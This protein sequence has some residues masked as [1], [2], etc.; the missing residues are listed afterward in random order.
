MARRTQF[1]IR[2][3]TRKLTDWAFGPD[4]NEVA[5]SASSKI[6]LTTAFAVTQPST[7]VRIRGYF[8]F[9]MLSTSALGDGMMG[10]LG[11][12]LVSDDAF[13]AGITAIPGP[14]SDANWDGWIF[15]SFWGVRS[16][17]G[18]IA[19]GANAVGAYYRMIVD[20]KAMRKWDPANT[21]VGVV[22]GVESGAM[23][24]EVNGETR[25]LLKVG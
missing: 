7:L 20:S 16:V 8:D 6:L 19:D 23:S 15:H 5:L 25:L 11:I 13:A 1:P 3:R 12:A 21:L 10:A 24:V 4:A 18:T 14:Q 2:G 9:C 22:E 17:T